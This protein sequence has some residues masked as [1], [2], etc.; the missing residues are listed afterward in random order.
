MGGK[1][2]G[3]ARSAGAFPVGWRIRPFRSLPRSRWSLGDRG[4]GDARGR[5]RGPPP[6]GAASVASDN[7]GLPGILTTSTGGKGCGTAAARRMSPTN[8][9]LL[10]EVWRAVPG[11]ACYRGRFAIRPGDRLT[12]PSAG[13]FLGPTRPS[14]SSGESAENEDLCLEGIPTPCLG[15]TGRHVPGVGA[16]QG[17]TRCVTLLDTATT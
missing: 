5:Q 7:G 14:A 8:P 4:P 17:T 11:P 1:L 6:Q 10:R 15:E 12:S 9:P 13:Q 3:T 2:C 16:C